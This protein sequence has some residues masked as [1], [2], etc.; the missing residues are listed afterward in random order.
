MNT[1]TSSAASHRPPDVPFSITVEPRPGAALVRLA[2]ACTM[3]V[4]STV[5]DHLVALA[6]PSTRLL[7]LE[8][9]KLDF[10]ESTGLGGVVAG[11]LRVRRNH[12][13]L[14]IVAP[15]PAIMALLEMTRLTQLFRVCDSVEEAL[16][17][18]IG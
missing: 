1:S 10:L 9:S 12:G 15:P 7:V 6:T 13:E 4:A 17:L 18:P 14:R 5:G 16:G 11:Y 2:G 8:L 3:D